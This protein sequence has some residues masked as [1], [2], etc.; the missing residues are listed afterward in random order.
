MARWLRCV[1]VIRLHY[2][3]VRRIGYVV[4][5]RISYVVVR[6]L[7]LASLGCLTA[8]S[9]DVLGCTV[10]GDFSIHLLDALH[11]AAKGIL[12]YTVYGDF[13]FMVT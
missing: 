7:E 6:R 2:V 10:D 8:Y 9:G 5:R 1:V 3:V 12:G 11:R 13:T 4:V